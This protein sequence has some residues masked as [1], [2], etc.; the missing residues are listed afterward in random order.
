MHIYNIFSEMT[1]SEE[2][3]AIDVNYDKTTINH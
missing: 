3:Q 2:C 1:F